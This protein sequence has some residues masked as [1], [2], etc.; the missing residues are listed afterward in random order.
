LVLLIAM[1]FARPKLVTELVTL[2]LD[3][4]LFSDYNGIHRAAHSSAA[5]HQRERT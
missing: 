2:V 5:A 4:S 3:N 1:A